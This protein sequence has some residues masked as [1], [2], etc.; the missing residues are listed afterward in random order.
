[1]ARIEDSNP[2]VVVA[3]AGL[4]A[5]LVA[6]GHLCRGSQDFVRAGLHGY[7][8]S[9]RILALLARTFERA[10]ALDAISL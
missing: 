5:P 1:M 8:G 7:E 2:D 9:R 4:H 3:S 6:R 10:E